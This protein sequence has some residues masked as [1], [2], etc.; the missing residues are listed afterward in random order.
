MV[1]AAKEGWVGGTELK[2]H[3]KTAEHT[4]DFATWRKK[5]G[6]V[7]RLGAAQGNASMTTGGNFT[8]HTTLS[9]KYAHTFISLS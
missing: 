4:L 8:L 3:Q 5:T 6:A 2:L 1:V 9:Q 7:L